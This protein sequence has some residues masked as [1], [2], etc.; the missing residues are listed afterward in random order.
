MKCQ[1]YTK[2]G[3]CKSNIFITYPSNPSFPHEHSFCYIHH[4]IVVRSTSRNQI[5]KFYN[6]Y[7]KIQELTL[8]S[9]GK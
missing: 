6:K 4:R 3:P 8:E 2:S 7:C 1:C 5:D 9:K